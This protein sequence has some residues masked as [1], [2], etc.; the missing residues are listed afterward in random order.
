M[1]PREV[2]V[3]LSVPRGTV[4]P[5]TLVRSTLLVSS[6]RSIRARGHFDRYLALLPSEHHDTIR[7]AIA[8]VWLSM[9]LAVAH[10]QACDG[11]GLPAE[12]Q[13]EI[14]REV[15]T[16]IQGTF[17]GTIVK[18]AKGAGV[19]PWALFAQYQ[20]LW[21][22]L[23]T[24]GGIEVTKV[25]PKEIVLECVN[26]SLVAIPYFRTAFRG[27]NIGGCELFSSKAYA[28]EVP[29]LSSATS[30]GIRVSWV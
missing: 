7:S 9:E 21:D 26:L 4:P 5:V 1:P 30:L 25:G 19:S 17:L 14:G 13:V 16:A 24:G 22:R 23:L 29:A 15:G 11:L 18:M 20:K 10:Y 27:V 12:E 6:L 3:P 8:G 2:L 28:S